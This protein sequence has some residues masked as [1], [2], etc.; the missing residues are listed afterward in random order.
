MSQGHKSILIQAPT[1]AGKTLLTAAM[2]KAASEKGM[3]SWFIVHRR[4]LLEQS[5]EAFIKMGINPGVISSNKMYQA[6]LPVYVCGIQTLVNRIDALKPPNLV[7]WDECQHNRAASWEKVRSYCARSFHVGLSA[8]PCRLDGKG[9]GSHFEQMINGPSVEWLMAN[10]FLSNYKLYAPQGFDYS[11]LHKRAGEYIQ[12]ETEER[13]NKPSI[14]GD[15]VSHYIRYARGMQAICFAVSIKHSRNLTEAFN[16]HGIISAHLDGEASQ[17][18]RYETMA[19]FRARKIQVLCNVDLFGEGL[20]VPGIECVVL[21]RPTASVSLYLQSVGR[22]LRPAP[23]KSHAVIID[24]VRNCERHGLPDDER[25]WSLED[26]EVKKG[27]AGPGVRICKTCFTANKATDLKCVQCGANLKSG[28]KEREVDV[29]KGELEEV[30]LEA[31]KAQRKK[32]QGVA[33]TEEQLI[34]LGKARGYKRPHLWARHVLRARG[35]R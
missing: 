23:G 15:V 1:G 21:A 6:G 3:K 4:E 5:F 19:K 12:S 31:L 7:V 9:L 25:E 30:D 27:K 28:V 33:Q 2:L 22:A 13:V 34:E 16:K 17:H 29:Q 20:D 35:G 18:E 26:G 32:E 14:V 8:T 11:G 10:G 24:A